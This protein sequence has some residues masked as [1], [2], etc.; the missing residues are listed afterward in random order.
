MAE[1]DDAHAIGAYVEESE[2]FAPRWAQDAASFRTDIGDRARLAVPYG[3]SERMIF[4]H[5]SPEGEAR[6]T[7]IFIHGGHWL[8]CD[9]SCWSHLAAGVLAQAWGCA[10]AV[11][12][13]EHH[14][15]VIEG[16]SDPAS[17]MI[18]RLTTLP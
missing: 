13:G 18:A 8:K 17:D 7:F 3:P 15:N 10:H 12:P 9:P 2:G 14:F 6:G 4:D 1:L 16:L 5:F 11:I